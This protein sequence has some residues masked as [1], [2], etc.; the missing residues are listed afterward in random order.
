MKKKTVMSNKQ[1]NEYIEKT[2]DFIKQNIV[3]QRS[4]KEVK[5]NYYTKKY[6]AK[7]RD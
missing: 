5:Y 2:E 6:L 3:K 4:Y 1:G 7:L